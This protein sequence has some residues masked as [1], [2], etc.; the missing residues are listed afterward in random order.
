MFSFER[1]MSVLIKYVLNRYRPEGCMVEGWSTE[2]AIEFYTNYLGLNRIG[3]PVSRH[4]GRL[5]GRGMI[6]E[7]SVRVEVDAFWQVLIS[8]S[9]TKEA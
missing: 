6:G 1:L 5:Q 4:E 9:F 2:E 3:V 7:G 8:L